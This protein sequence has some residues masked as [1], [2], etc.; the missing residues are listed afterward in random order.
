MTLQYYLKR[1]SPDY[2]KCDGQIDKTLPRLTSG[3][4][5]KTCGRQLHPPYYLYYGGGKRLYSNPCMNSGDEAI[6]TIKIAELIKCQNQG[7]DLDSF[8]RPGD[9]TEQGRIALRDDYIN[10]RLR[11]KMRL[12]QKCYD[13]YKKVDEEISEA[14]LRHHEMLSLERKIHSQHESER[15][16][17]PIESCTSVLERY[18]MSL[19]DRSY[20]LEKEL[21]FNVLDEYWT[22][23]SIDE[24]RY[25][26]ALLSAIF[27]TADP[28]VLAKSG[29]SFTS[30]FIIQI[31][32]DIR[33][34]FIK[35]AGKIFP[36]DQELTAY[37]IQNVKNELQIQY[38]K[39]FD[40]GFTKKDNRRFSIIIH[41]S[42]PKGYWVD[43]EIPTVHRTGIH[44]RGCICSPIWS[45][46]ESNL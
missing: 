32:K 12:C 46:S 7:L 36:N 4:H 26:E 10:S 39:I 27:S 37:M 3:A 5:S 33:T 17:K 2:G 22:N 29:M 21:G 1:L 18:L 30:E 14:Y 31:R 38:C 11:S 35:D 42:H 13:R 8:I 23:W 43:Y 15:R 28:E 40:L 9:S 6:Q 44:I 41:C 34:N 16:N 24:S 20:M 25:M 19:P 45:E